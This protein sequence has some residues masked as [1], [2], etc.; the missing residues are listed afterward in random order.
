MTYSF[1]LTG[2][3]TQLI[4]ES[5]AA[6]PFRLVAALIQKLQGQAASQQVKP[7][8]APTPDAPAKE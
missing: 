2:E 4:L 5:L 1:E 3:E 7:T 8:E 6:Q